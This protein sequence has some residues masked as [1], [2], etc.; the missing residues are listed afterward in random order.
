LLD[1]QVAEITPTLADFGLGFHVRNP[2][3]L[4]LHAPCAS[5]G[6]KPGLHYADESRLRAAVGYGEL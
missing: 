2:M 6:L 5:M 1:Q 3:R 4:P